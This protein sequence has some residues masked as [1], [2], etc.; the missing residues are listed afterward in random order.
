MNNTNRLLI[1]LLLI[2]PLFGCSQS[3]GTE[4]TGVY[5][6]TLVA[7][8]SGI[9]PM[10][11]SVNTE[12]MFGWFGNM[13]L[14]TLGAILFMG[15]FHSTGEP[16][17]SFAATGYILFVSASL[18]RVLELVGDD[19]VFVTLVLAAMATASLFLGK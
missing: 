18:M 1:L 12:L 5:N 4:H 14:I 19:A 6:L 2:M 10:M 13:F 9:V 8:N 15:F 3:P 16:N 7:N 11:Q 17:K